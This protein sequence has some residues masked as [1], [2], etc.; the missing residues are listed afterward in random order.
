MHPHVQNYDQP[1][2]VED[3]FANTDKAPL[4]AG[5]KKGVSVHVSSFAK[6]VM[7][8]LSVWSEVKDSSNEYKRGALYLHIPFCV[9]RCKFC[10]FYK[11]RTHHGELEKYTNYILKE[12]DMVSKSV[13]AQSTSIAAVY[14]GGG[15]PTDLSAA[16]FQRILSHLNSNWNLTNDCEITVEG[17]LF[18]FGD[19][20]IAACIDGGVNRFSFGVQSFN[21]KVRRQ[22]G[23]ID[24]KETILQRIE[25]VSKQSQ[26]LTS[27]DLIYG[28]PDQTK[29]IWLE[30][31][32]TAYETRGIDSCS[33]Y[34]LKFLPGSPIKD[35]VDKGEI[36]P[37]ATACEQADLFSV[38]NNY[39]NALNAKRLG[40]RHW[41]FSN[42]ERS[43][44]N[45]IAKYEKPCIP[46]GSGAGGIISNYRVFQAM[47]L[48]SYYSKI[49]NNEKPIAMALNL[50]NKKRVSGSII[51]S[52]EEFLQID[53]KKIQSRFDDSSMIDVLSPL[54]T[55]WQDAGMVTFDK[56]SG[57]MK[58][59]EPGQ[60][61]NVHIG[62]H[63][64]DYLNWKGLKQ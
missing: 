13:Y 25:E 4:Y 55:Q 59:R 58:L 1:K 6:P 35:M 39:F 40:L 43:I 21:T 50:G 3:F 54:L 18:G 30:D 8:P 53:F 60:F 51:G 17:R 36:S 2:S 41:S 57:V 12:L 5:F 24:K 19:D 48:N 9:A 63:L 10:S 33:I 7:D 49:E 64:L 20:K 32:K 38:T 61:Y 15:T 34:N 42:R 26:I 14:F 16:S 11:S 52:M 23:R 56:R 45:F 27:V 31:L 29:E 44:Y 28:L 46:I 22:M 37:P 47:D 62:Q